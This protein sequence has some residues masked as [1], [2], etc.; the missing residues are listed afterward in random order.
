MATE[1]RLISLKCPSCGAEL[2]IEDGRDI[3][4]CTYCGAKI[5]VEQSDETVKARSRERIVNDISSKIG[6]YARERREY[7]ERQKREADK[8]F[9]ICMGILFLMLLAIQIYSKLNGGW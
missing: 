4:F 9:F 3:C 5:L 2:N 7:K 6:D 1:T 8:K